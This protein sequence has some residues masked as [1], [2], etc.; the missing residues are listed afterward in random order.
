MGGYKPGRGQIADNLEVTGQAYSSINTL[1]DGVNIATN[2]DDG[3]SHKVTLGGNRTLSN[4]TNMQTGA[5]YLWIIVQDGTGGRTLAYGNKF[6]FPGGG[7]PVLS[8]TAN[9]VDLLSAVYDGT[10]FL[11]NLSKT[12]S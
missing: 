10:N 9:A 5:T 8:T 12:Y 1:T 7:E 6:K 2:C 4:P 3:N 11:A